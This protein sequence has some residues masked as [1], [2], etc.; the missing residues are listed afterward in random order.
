MGP[1]YQFNQL[2]LVTAGRNWMISNNQATDNGQPPGN[3]TTYGF[4]FENWP[5]AKT[6]HIFLIGNTAVDNQKVGT[7]ARG[8]SFGT[9]G[10]HTN[11]HMS[12][13][14]AKGNKVDYF[15]GPSIN[16]PTLTEGQINVGSK[17]KVSMTS[18]ELIA[19]CCAI[20]LRNRM[21]LACKV[22]FVS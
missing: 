19:S 4:A 8:F 1:G 12:G 10:I 17:G 11:V 2:S 7:Q 18:A 3:S 9:H 15:L 13:N 6:D 16:L 22:S 21:R 20:A 5:G 14:V